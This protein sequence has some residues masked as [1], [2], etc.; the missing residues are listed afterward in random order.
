MMKKEAGVYLYTMLFLQ[1][2]FD[3]EEG[4]CSWCL[5]IYDAVLAGCLGIVCGWHRDAHFPVSAVH[6][7]DPNLTHCTSVTPG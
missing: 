1:V 6:A 5:F 4:I 2:T 7:S 3:N